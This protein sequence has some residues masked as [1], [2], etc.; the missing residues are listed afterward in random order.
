VP[1]PPPHWRAGFAKHQRSSMLR[2]ALL[3]APLALLAGSS[4]AADEAKGEKIEFATYPG[5]FEKNNAGLKGDASY[6]ALPDKDAF[7]KV[8]QL[9]PPLMKGNK[10][11]P[12]PD[13]A[14]EKQVVGIIKR[15]NSITTY[16]VEKVTADGDTIYVQYKAEAGPAGTAT[17][18]SPLVVAVDKGKAKK[19]AFIENGKTVATVDVKEKN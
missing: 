6:L 15:G 10:A 17:F 18:A 8:F 14:F 16:T 7:A 12:L 5:Y 4:R 9:R 2:L 19:V 11:V 13:N 3:A 1:L